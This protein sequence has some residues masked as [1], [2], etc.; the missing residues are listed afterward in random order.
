MFPGSSSFTCLKKVFYLQGTNKYPT[1]VGYK[2]SRK[3]TPKTK[4]L[5]LPPWKRRNIYQSPILGFQ[6]L[7]FLGGVIYL[8]SSIAPI[9]QESLPLA[10]PSELQIGL[11]KKPCMF[12]PALRW[13]YRS[14]LV[15]ISEMKWVSLSLWGMDF[16]KLVIFLRKGDEILPVA[17]HDFSKFLW[18]PL[19]R[20]TFLCT[21]LWQHQNWIPFLADFLSTFFVKVGILLPTCIAPPCMLVWWCSSCFDDVHLLLA[22]TNPIR[23]L[24]ST[25]L[26]FHFFLIQPFDWMFNFHLCLP[27]SSPFHGQKT[28]TQ[29]TCRVYHKVVYDSG[30]KIGHPP[31]LKGSHPSSACWVFGWEWC[32][33]VDVRMAKKRRYFELKAE[34]NVSLYIGTWYKNNSYVHIDIN[35]TMRTL[36]ELVAFA[37]QPGNIGF[38][39]C[40]KILLMDESYLVTDW[41]CHRNPQLPDRLRQG[42]LRNSL[43]LLASWIDI[44]VYEGQSAWCVEIY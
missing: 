32:W 15:F 3:Y 28:G 30:P 39:S 20:K 43:G 9:Q 5:N 23:P 7:V 31:R 21:A 44:T 27:I 29:L 6:R 34:S 41:P 1:L 24:D 38:F 42:P 2:L 4:N 11:S 36:L 19:K 8:L 40:R 37:W 26:S 35:C 18:N 25:P 22:A 16:I 10:G 33:D 17:R 13:N 14:R 12:F